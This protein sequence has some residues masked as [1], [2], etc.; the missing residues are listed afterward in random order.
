[1][2]T[3]KVIDKCALIYSGEEQLNLVVGPYHLFSVEQGW[4]V[5]SWLNQATVQLLLSKCT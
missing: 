4:D 2:L 3:S 5:S 1:M